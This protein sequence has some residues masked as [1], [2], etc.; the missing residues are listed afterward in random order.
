M[1]NLRPVGNVSITAKAPKVFLL[2]KA[3]LGNCLVGSM[4]NSAFLRN[5][6]DVLKNSARKLQRDAKQTLQATNKTYSSSQT[7]R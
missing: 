1:K 2:L 7:S 6:S 5:D 4:E 3:T